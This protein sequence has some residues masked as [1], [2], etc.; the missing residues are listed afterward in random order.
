MDIPE[1]PSTLDTQDEVKQNK[2]Q[3]TIFFLNEQCGHHQTWAEHRCSRRVCI[4]VSYKTST[5]L[6]QS[7]K[8]LC[9]IKERKNLCKRKKILYYLRN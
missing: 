5:V 3:I 6:V 9:V 2:K 8:V 7:I 1:T 4:P